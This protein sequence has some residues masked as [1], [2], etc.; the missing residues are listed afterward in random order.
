MQDRFC[1]LLII[2]KKGVTLQN[3][4]VRFNSTFNI[5]H[6]KFLFYVSFSRK[7]GSIV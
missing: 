5:Q 1:E 6:S 4:E 3:K 2:W 7:K